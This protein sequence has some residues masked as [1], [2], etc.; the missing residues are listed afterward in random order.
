M[1]PTVCLHDSAG[2]L[3]RMVFTRYASSE[4]QFGDLREVVARER[5][6]ALSWKARLSA[7][8]RASVFLHV[9]FNE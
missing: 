9:L 7:A 1:Q 2:R 4:L 5:H 3:I 8:A 6:R